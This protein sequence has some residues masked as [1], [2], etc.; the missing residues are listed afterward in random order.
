VG[1]CHH[2]NG[3]SS[4]YCDGD[5]DP[6]AA[7]SAAQKEIYSD[8]IGRLVLPTV[9]GN[10]AVAYFT[11]NNNFT[12]PYILTGVRIVSQIDDASPEIPLAGKSG[13]YE[14]IGKTVRQ[15]EQVRIPPCGSVTFSP[16]GKQVMFFGLMPKE[17]PGQRAYAY[18][19][20]G[21]DNSQSAVELQIES[22][23]SAASNSAPAQKM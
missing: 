10:P 19:S 7:Y 6:N 12:D 18:L 1:G 15:L 22:A 17:K 2:S 4:R 21:G 3:S 5:R 8:S 13:M 9:K 20:F 11:I 23:G 14:N 16:G